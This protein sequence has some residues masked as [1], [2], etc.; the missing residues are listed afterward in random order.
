MPMVVAGAALSAISVSFAGGALAFGFSLSSF[1]GSLI[2]GGLSYA[3]TPKPKKPAMP[4]LKSNGSTV[5]I[6]Q[7]D[8]TR[9]HVYG[10]ARVVRGYAQINSTGVNGTIH[11]ILLLCEGELRAINEIWV[12]DY[13]IPPDWIDADGNVTQGRYAGKLVIRKHLGGPTQTADSVA[14]AQMPE[15]N[16]NCRLYGIAYLYLQLIKDQDVYPTGMPNFTAIVEGPARY[17]PRIGEDRWST[18]IP[19]HLADF[20]RTE[21]GFAAFDEDVD[22][23][24]ISAQMN[25]ADEIVD[26]PEKDFPVTAVN[27]STD[28]ITL[29]LDLLPLL[30]GAR[31]RISSTG[32][33]PAGLSGG[34]DY[35]VIPY[36]I[37]D[38]ARI[39][40]ATSLE[41]AMAKVAV[42][43]TSAG[44]GDI[45]ITQTGEPRYHGSGA[46]DTET[47]LSQI[48]NDLAS[49]MA[50]RTVEIAGRWTLLAG[51]W[52][53]PDMTY[54]IDDI[55]GEGFG[56]KNGLTMADSYNVVNGL[57]ISPL[58][59]Y[60][61]SNYPSA[62][63]QAFIDDDNGIEAAKEL[64]LPYC[65]SSTA[66][67]RIAK[68][69]L[70]RGRQDIIYKSA[71]SMKAFQSKPGDVI[72]LE[73]DRLGW[74]G[75]YF[76]VTEFS[77]DVNDGA[78]QT[79]MVLRETAQ[80]I[81]DWTHG[82]AIDYDPA[83]NTDLPDPF[84]VPP[85]GLI[86]LDSV[87][88]YTVMGDAVVKIAMSWP[89]VDDAL[90]TN[91]GKIEI[92]YKLATEMGWTAYPLINGDRVSADLFQAQIGQLYDIRIRAI[93]RVGVRG[94]WNTVENFQAG[95]TL[96]PD[97]EDWE[98]ETL[99]P[100]EDW[101]TDS[102][103]P[104]DWA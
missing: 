83:P 96:V 61:S 17:D 10:H 97:R 52:R 73:I 54:G 6:R 100:D 46:F 35:Y 94:P 11:S 81:Y 38:S 68:I 14:V 59:L 101:E 47:P 67:Q 7:S 30:F 102:L 27:T 84:H 92:Q 43:I 3:L 41:N 65:N 44:T 99:T 79:V 66:A 77:F 9:Q 29:G 51:A 62:R 2:L 37:K 40:L 19:Q 70:F 45:T 33:I 24:N 95:S 56:V 22:E 8:L 74:S 64:N 86:G 5:A 89:L 15:W 57:F 36:Q 60:Q 75:K 103:T 50:G 55:R 53:T 82:E 88:I 13:C 32:S 72:G 12:N 90:V 69:E 28:I 1:A 63:Y 85:I 31:V 87:P 49:C 58:T 76:E 16:A 23:D 78:L 20:I 80:A 18:N 104:E 34:T 48:A 39:L 25:I 71:F 21:K 93:N 98:H 4:D 26:L 42:N 91:D